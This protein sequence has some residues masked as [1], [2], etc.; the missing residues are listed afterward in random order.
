MLE[1]VIKELRDVPLKFVYSN[2]LLK[3]KLLAQLLLHYFGDLLAV[4]SFIFH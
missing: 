2:E 3:G 4:L 1:Q